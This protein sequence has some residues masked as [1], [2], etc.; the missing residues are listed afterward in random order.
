MPTNN[1]TAHVNNKVWYVSY[2]YYFRLSTISYIIL[3]PS[4]EISPNVSSVSDVRVK[5]LQGG[6]HLRMT[7][8]EIH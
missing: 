8:G 5:L 3:Q 1:L 7:I 4:G 6:G 2:T